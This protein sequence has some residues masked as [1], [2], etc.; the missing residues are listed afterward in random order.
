M[1]SSPAF[2]L[3]PI[4]KSSS[5]GQCSEELEM[6]PASG[7]RLLEARLG[8]LLGGAPPAFANA[9]L[10]LLLQLPS[11]Q[12]EYLPF[13]ACLPRKPSSASLAMIG[14]PLAGKCPSSPRYQNRI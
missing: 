8:P 3:Q 2:A 10:S 1:P 9:V 12:A 4:N 6:L 7:R 14:F 13:K 11:L 5:S